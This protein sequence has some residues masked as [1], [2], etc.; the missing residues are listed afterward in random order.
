MEKR[1]LEFCEKQDLFTPHRRV[2]VA[3]SGGLDSMNLYELLYKNKERLKIHL[4]LAH[5]NHGQRPESDLEESELR[6]L[7]DRRETRIHV[8][9]YSG[10]FTEAKAR[11]FRYDFFKQ[12]MEKE[13]CTALVTGHHANDQAET[14]FMRLIRGTKLRHLSG[15]PVR[16][17]FGKGEL[18]RP[19]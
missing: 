3:L 12:I 18:I 17:P 2:L 1:F 7:A 16:Q 19:L 14:T 10:D 15:I 13:D 11:T 5:V 6:T 4:V 8:A 9:H